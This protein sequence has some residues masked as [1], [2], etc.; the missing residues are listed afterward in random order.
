MFTREQKGRFCSLFLSC[1]RIER[2]PSRLASQDI[3]V[4]KYPVAIIR[5]FI[6]WIFL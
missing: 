3:E 6:A 1:G 2:N 5:V 4:N